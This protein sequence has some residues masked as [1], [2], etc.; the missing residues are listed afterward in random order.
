MSNVAALSN[1]NARINR[2]LCA[3][4]EAFRVLV[5]PAKHGVTMQ[6]AICQFMQAS[7]EVTAA[8]RARDESR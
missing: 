5:S 3:Y 7:T 6:E 1:L 2:A 4:E 8:Y